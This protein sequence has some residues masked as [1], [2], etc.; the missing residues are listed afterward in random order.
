VR[1]LIVEDEVRL[2]S[3]LQRGLAAEGFTVDLAHTG[4]DGLHLAQES[5]Y[6]LVILDIMLPGLSGYRIIEHLR[7]AQNWVPILMLTT[8]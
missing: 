2:A 3:A 4:P 1:L 7:A 5:T 6:D 8:T